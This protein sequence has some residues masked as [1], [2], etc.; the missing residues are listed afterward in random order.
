V[1]NFGLNLKE[2]IP[3]G[4]IKYKKSTIG[5]QSIIQKYFFHQWVPKGAR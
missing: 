2:Y 4:G 1:G 3:I 5:N